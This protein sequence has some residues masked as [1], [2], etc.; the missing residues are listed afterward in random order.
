KLGGKYPASFA[1]ERTIA[2][3]E[4]R[5]YL[6]QAFKQAE[7]VGETR[8]NNVIYLLDYSP[9][10]PVML[11]IGRLREIAFRKVGEGSGKRRDLDAYDRHYRHL[12]LWDRERLEIA[13]AYRLGEG[14]RILAGQG[15]AGL[16]TRSLYHYLPAFYPY[17]EQAVE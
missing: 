15:E 14:A 3:P 12:V 6:Q 5:Q 9:G 11:E 1:T 2:R 7:Q 13:G 10:S 17:L 16:Y 4:N 8:D